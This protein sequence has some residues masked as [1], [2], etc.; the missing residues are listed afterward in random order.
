MISSE[1]LLVIGMFA[2]TGRLVWGL[3]SL[4]TGKILTKAYGAVDGRSV[5]TRFAYRDQEPVWF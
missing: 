4:F 2:A 1:A 5:Y 3:S